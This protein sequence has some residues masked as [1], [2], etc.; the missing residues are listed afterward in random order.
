MRKW[1]FGFA[2]LPNLGGKHLFFS[3]KIESVPPLSFIMSLFSQTKK[4][5][6]LIIDLHILLTASILNIIHIYITM[7]YHT[8]EK[9]R[10]LDSQITT[11]LYRYLFLWNLALCSQR[12]LFFPQGF[13]WDRCSTWHLKQLRDEIKK[14]RFALKKWYSRRKESLFQKCCSFCFNKN[15]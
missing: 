15:V 3:F 2:M 13:C 9:R 4:G 7:T 5:C 1:G 11:S 12:L 6:G 8:N 10:D 14:R